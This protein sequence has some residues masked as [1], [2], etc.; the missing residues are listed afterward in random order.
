[1][2][3]AA[4]IE[5]TGPASEIHFGDLEVPVAGDGQI[6]VRTGAVSVNPI[7]T[8]IRSGA[9][10]A[11]LPKPYIIGCDIAGTVAAIGPGVSG[12]HPG[13]RV[14]G[15]NQG[16][17]GRQGTFSEL[18]AVDECWLYPTPD[19]VSD[20]AVAAIALTG[21]TAHL[22]LFLHGG[23]RA[24]E[25]VFVNGG[26]GGVGSAVVQLAK[27]VGAT[28]ITTVGSEEKRQTAREL[29]ADL[30]I[31]YRSENVAETLQQSVAQTGPINVWFETLR[32]P[33]PDVTIPLLAKRGRYILMA[34]RDAR[35]EFPVGPFYV[36]DLRAIGFAMFNAS[37]AEQRE[38][39]LEINDLL[40]KGTLK[41][42][43]GARF[44]LCDAIQA[45][46]LQEDNTLSG[47]G[48]LSGKIVLTP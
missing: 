35:P 38:A 43:I 4:Y 42:L 17:A 20:E 44:P 5:S 34:G 10:Q 36:R 25:V 48:T 41:P 21:I 13:D 11:E 3:K 29:G 47:A 19:N 27:A 40:T 1:M 23:L 39:A 6:L 33:V 28:V 26:T 22:G 14:W 24:G 7:D 8:Y 45:H 31:N 46:Q 32:N 37:A 9:V 15:S 2:M 30:V 12:F 18:A 16:L